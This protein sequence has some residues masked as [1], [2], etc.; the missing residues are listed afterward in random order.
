MS[1]DEVLRLLREREAACRGEAERLR[2]EAER[3]RGELEHVDAQLARA[4]TIV[5][6]LLARLRGPAPGHA[7]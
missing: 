1:C 2:A 6:D 3:S 7:Q 4:I 5:N